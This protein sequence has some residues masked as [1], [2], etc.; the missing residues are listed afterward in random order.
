V[1][2]RR[3]GIVVQPYHS[4]DEG[5]NDTNEQPDRAAAVA[6]IETIQALYRRMESMPQ[7]KG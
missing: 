6:G 5:W 2:A 1:L 4:E 7:K 3:D